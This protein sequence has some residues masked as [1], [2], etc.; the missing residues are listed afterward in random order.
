MYSCYFE[1]VDGEREVGRRWMRS[2]GGVSLELLMVGIA[3]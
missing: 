3:L 2:S 1:C